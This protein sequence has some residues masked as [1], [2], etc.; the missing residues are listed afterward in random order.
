MRRGLWAP[1][2]R[3]MGTTEPLVDEE[4]REANA[5]MLLFEPLGWSE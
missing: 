1:L 2:E 3:K 4:L 5:R